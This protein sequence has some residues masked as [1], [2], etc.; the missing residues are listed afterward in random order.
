MKE[1]EES[2]WVYLLAEGEVRLYSNHNPFTGIA[3]RNDHAGLDS[4]AAI[5]QMANASA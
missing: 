1:K 2:K 3:F 4:Q 5:S